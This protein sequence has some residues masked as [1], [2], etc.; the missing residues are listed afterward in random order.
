M[1]HRL[2]GCGVVGQRRRLAVALPPARVVFVASDG[3]QWIDV[4]RLARLD[5]LLT[6]VAAIGDQAFHGAEHAGLRLEGGQHRLDLLFVVGCL[7]DTGGNDQH[8]CRI[9][10]R[11]GVVRLFEATTGDR[12][13]ARL[14][15]S[16]IDLIFV[17]GSWLWRLWGLAARLLAGRFFL[18]GTQGH[19]LVV[20]GLLALIALLGPGDKLGLGGRHR[21]QP[22]FATLEFL[23]QADTRRD[24]GLIGL[25]RQRQQFLNLGFE[26]SFQL[27]DVAV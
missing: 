22:I 20:L 5:V 24:V 10:R 7:R 26:L 8:R 21:R 4:S 12:H 2:N 1:G 15:V 25:F 9:S 3:D 19:F 27:F 16:Q 23:G 17:P 13:D 18:G 11:L 14:F 6:T